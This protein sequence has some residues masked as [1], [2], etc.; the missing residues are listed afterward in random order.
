MVR[1]LPSRNACLRLV[2]NTVT[3]RRKYMQYLLWLS[4]D[5]GA[6]K[7]LAFDAMCRGWALG[8]KDF[9]KAVLQE[10]LE[11]DEVGDSEFED[12]SLS[13]ANELIWES[14]L[15]CAMAHFGKTN[16][17]IESNIKSANWKAG[18]ASLLKKRTEHMDHIAFEYRCFS[19]SEPLCEYT[20]Q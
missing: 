1:T 14:L 11:K 19:S 4:E 2:R 6:R 20:S 5:T 13:K 16:T 3:G 8:S 17:D 18:I 12:R 10:E 7:E 9:K 15:E